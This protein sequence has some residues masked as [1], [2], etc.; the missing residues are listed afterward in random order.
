MFTFL[1][2]STIKNTCSRNLLW[3]YDYMG[4]F[5][6]VLRIVCLWLL[7][8]VALSPLWWFDPKSIWPYEVGLSSLSTFW[9][10]PHFYHSSMHFQINVLNLLSPQINIAFYII[11]YFRSRRPIWSIH[12]F[13]SSRPS[14]IIN[15]NFVDFFL[16]SHGCYKLVYNFVLWLK[17]N[18]NFSNSM[19]NLKLIIML[20]SP[21][22][23]PLLVEYL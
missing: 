23:Y 12:T 2:R 20:L 3:Y 17:Q 1:T 4:F 14:T 15:Q 11:L 8:C 22:L 9:T 6:W 13:N 5:M 19:S 16:R 18:F 7:G 21:N 10:Y